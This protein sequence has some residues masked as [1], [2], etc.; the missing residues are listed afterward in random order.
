[1]TRNSSKSKVRKR[2]LEV[3]SE[4]TAWRWWGDFRVLESEALLLETPSSP[5]SGRERERESKERRVGGKVVKMGRVERQTE[6]TKSL[7][8]EDERVTHTPRLT[9]P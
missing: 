7:P 3:F 5:V 8:Q 9:R 1:M 2:M 4:R 6:K